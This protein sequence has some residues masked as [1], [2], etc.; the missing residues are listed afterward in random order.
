MIC[1]GFKGGI[2]TA[3][4]VLPP[5]FGGYT[6][7]MLAQCN[8]GERSELRIDGV[9]VG[10]EIPD[11]HWCYDADTPPAREWVRS[12]V[13]RCGET[14]V[15]AQPNPLAGMGS[16]IIVVATDAPLLPHQLKRLARRAALGLGLV[17]GQGENFSGDLMIAFSTAN[18]GAA[19]PGFTTLTMFPNQWMDVLF[20]ATI[21]ATQ[22]A[23]VNAMLAADTMTGA[24]SIR[25]FALPQDRLLDI[26]RRYNRLA[27]NQ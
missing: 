26:L 5:E 20:N 25:V 2:G 14:S 4:R 17:G 8:A 27:P 15:G 6:V 9:P 13:P 7:G 3:S 10:R 21:Q 1:F 19:E 16:I 18:P 24:D 22:E 23:I 12:A 11:L